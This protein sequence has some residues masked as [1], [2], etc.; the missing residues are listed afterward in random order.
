MILALI[1]LKFQMVNPGAVFFNFNV[2]WIIDL[3]SCLPKFIISTCRDFIVALLKFYPIDD[4]MDIQQPLALLEI[5]CAIQLI[6]RWWKFCQRW[7][8]GFHPPN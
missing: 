7:P 3:V 8:S 2:V 5:L 6:L 4:D 1:E